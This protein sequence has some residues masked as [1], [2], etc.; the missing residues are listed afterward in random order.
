VAYQDGS[1][2]VGV[3]VGFGN[4]STITDG[5]GAFTL[6]GVPH[7]GPFRLDA[8]AQGHLDREVWLGGGGMRGPVELDIIGEVPP[9]DHQFYRLFARGTSDAAASALPLLNWTVAPSVY[10]RTV[11]EDTG[12]PVAPDVID[13]IVGLM[14]ASIPELTGERFRVELVEL[15]EESR[16][17][18][19]PGWI[20]VLFFENHPRGDSTLGD[21]LLGG[22]SGRIR[23]R[24]DTT[25]VGTAAPVSAG[26][27][28]VV[29]VAEHEIVHAMGFSHTDRN[30]WDFN[31]ADG[32]TGHGRSERARFH[33]ALAYSRPRGNL[34]PD[35]DPLLPLPMAAQASAGRPV[36]VCTSTDIR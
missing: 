3:R 13:E 21:S 22:D 25:P 11:I 10:I 33:A 2:S 32:C 35:R 7:S 24:Y 16:G 15:G 23:L 4:A 12:E 17:E 9:F 20:D 34:D 14:Q 31:S 30:W 36:T 5:Q 18:P 29:Y 26:C 1:P 6:E 27:R 19:R 8:S 28:T